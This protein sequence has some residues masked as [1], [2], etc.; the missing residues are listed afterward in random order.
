[1]LLK[2]STLSYCVFTQER[3]DVKRFPESG[4]LD[5]SVED[6]AD[7]IRLVSVPSMGRRSKRPKILQEWHRRHTLRR[8]LMLTAKLRA[9]KLLKDIART[10]WNERCYPD[11]AYG[12]RHLGQRN[13]FP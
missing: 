9:R 3:K 7:L 6:L 10:P 12:L 1:M 2:S 13:D 11:P 5:G 4:W 8:F